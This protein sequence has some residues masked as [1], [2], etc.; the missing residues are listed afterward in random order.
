MWGTILDHTIYV[1]LLPIM[2]FQIHLLAKECT[3]LPTIA[4][5][6]TDS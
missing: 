5:W 2:R 1:Y 3:G 4:L 6:Y